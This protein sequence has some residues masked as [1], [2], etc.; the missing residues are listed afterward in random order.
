M[1]EML[2]MDVQGPE[3]EHEQGSCQDGE[4]SVDI[5][6]P[7]VRCTKISS[8]KLT[9]HSN[10]QEYDDTEELRGSCK[11]AANCTYD[12]KGHQDCKDN[13]LRV[14]VRCS[15]SAGHD[16]CVPSF[17]SGQGC[18]WCYGDKPCGPQHWG[19]NRR[20][21]VIESNFLMMIKTIF[22]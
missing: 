18:H 1:R 2:E 7:E 5:Q 10:G 15:C 9:C 22:V 21:K 20:W 17:V 19:R 12:A 4:N 11:K 13:T 6:C 14:R 8:A 3:V 16:N